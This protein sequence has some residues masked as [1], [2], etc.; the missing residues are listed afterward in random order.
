MTQMSALERRYRRLLAWYPAEHRGIH[1]EEMI[2]VLLAGAR[3]GQLRPML[4]DALDLIMGGLRI[5][6]R[7]VMAG[8]FGGSLIDALTVY[9][10]AMPIMWVI[11]IVVS[12]A[13]AIN[14]LS[15]AAA[16]LTSQEIILTAVIPVALLTLMGL[17]IVLA[18]RGKRR[19]A[20]AIAFV[21]AAF[22][23]IVAFMPFARSGSAFTAA[24][25]LLLVLQVVAL[26]TSPGPRRA[27]QLLNAR[28]WLVICA[29]G[30]A[31]S[32]PLALYQIPSAGT[33]AGALVG[34]GAA[35][36]AAA[37]VGMLVTLPRGI[38]PR[39]FALLAAPVYLGGIS[40]ATAYRGGSLISYSFAIVYVP[41]LVLTVLLGILAW[42]G[43]RRR[44]EPTG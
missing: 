41:T 7:A 18:W 5:R 44:L 3:E 22:F 2:G 24:D 12:E 9:S 40:I 27:V 36:A 43:G 25:S 11:A 20:A 32:V 10:I 42:R 23:S 4:P 6:L 30:L 34:L 39:L 38:A 17:P 21:P 16:S 35:V 33:P 15:M 14:S 26:S 1:G 28:A 37:A 13:I 29:S 31:A 19:A 8:Q